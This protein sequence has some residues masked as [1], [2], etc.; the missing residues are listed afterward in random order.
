MCPD[1]VDP[2]NGQV[3]Y[4]PDILALFDFGTVATYQCHSGYA[5]RGGDGTRTCGSDSTIITGTWSGN[6]PTCER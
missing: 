5:L 6:A 4:S 3:T 1:L 2:E